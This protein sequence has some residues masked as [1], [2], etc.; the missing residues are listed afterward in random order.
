NQVYLL[1]SPDAPR[2]ERRSNV[3]LWD[4][5]LKVLRRRLLR[6][7]CMAIISRGLRLTRIN[8]ARNTALGP[9]H[10]SHPTLPVRVSTS[11]LWL[12]SCLRTVGARQLR[13]QSDPR[14]MISD[15]LLSLGS[16]IIICLPA[17]KNLCVLICGAFWATSLGMGCNLML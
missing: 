3:A 6:C 12:L 7:R 2:E 1:G 9:L 8:T 15:T 11:R 4:T 17:T 5:P 10:L 13:H 16:T 14:P